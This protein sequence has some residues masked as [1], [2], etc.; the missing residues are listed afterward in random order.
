M[1]AH[2]FRT[3]AE[4]IEAGYRLVN[5]RNDRD[6]S[7]PNSFGYSYES[8]SGE[9]TVTVWFTEETNK[10]GRLGAFAAMYPPRV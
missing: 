4:A 1:K 5:R 6:T 10:I 8:E 7:G 9:K 2:E 3:K